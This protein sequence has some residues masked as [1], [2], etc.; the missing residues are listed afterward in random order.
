[1]P[2]ADTLPVR[3]RRP[4]AQRV[5]CGERALH[6]AARHQ[7]AD[8]PARGRARPRGVRPPGQAARVDDAGRRSGRR[9]RAPRARRDP[10]HEGG[11]R[12]LPCRG[13]R[14]ARDRDDAH[15]GALCA[16]KGAAGVRRALS[17][18]AGDAA[19]GQPAPGR[20][21]GGQW[22]GR[23][24]DRHRGGERVPGAGVASLLRMEPLR[25]GA[26]R[27]SAREG[28][29]SADARGDREVADRHL[30]LLVHGPLAGQR[31]VRG[32]RTRAQHRADRAR[33]RCHQ[34][35]RRAR[36]GHRHHRRDGVR[37]AQGHDV[38]APRRRAPVRA[39]DDAARRAPRRVRARLRLHVHRHVR[40]AVQPRGDRGGARSPLGRGAR[41]LTRAAALPRS[42]GF[43]ALLASLAMIGPFS[44]DLY[45]PAFP[46]IAQ[47]FDVAPIA[48]QQ[49]LSVYLFAYA[50][51][52]LWH[53][54]LSDAFGRRP[55][56]IGALCVYAIA[57]L[58]CAIA[59]N[60]QSLWLFRALQGISAGGPLV[61][62]RA[63]IRDRLH[64]ADAQRLM[65]QVTMVF[66]AA[67]A[68]APIVGGI[69][70]N[71]LGW[72]AI[73]W[74]LLAFVIA[75]IVWTARALDETLPKQSRQPL[76]ARRMWHNYVAVLTHRDFLMLAAVPA[77]NFA[78]FFIYVALAPTFLIDKLGVSTWGFAV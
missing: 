6:V 11:R 76:D 40:A 4:R 56:V 22:R 41:D 58:G 12:G 29:R 13:Q 64:G 17:Q 65:S 25:A 9:H 10:Q 55:V 32:A 35:L 74:V 24:G 53:G 39:G 19:P 14:H 46:A 60:I 66:G 34:D 57:T 8:P 3:R 52:M 45:L 54:A 70:L 37:P 23:R 36:H 72:R 27:S 73:F 28:Q 43:A 51:M 7:Q 42:W 62:G 47:G 2:P 30:R 15:A 69:L 26:Q 48:V 44:I 68:I 75:T 21:A 18:G 20:R 38:R 71:T 61:V 5:G 33:R 67:P 63:V 16:A 77:L 1:E 31:R 59:G 50:G 78:A 49:T